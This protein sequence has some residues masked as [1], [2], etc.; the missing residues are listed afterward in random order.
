MVVLRPSK[1]ARTAAAMV[2]VAAC[3]P[4]AGIEEK[5]CVPACVDEKT[6]LV[7]D[8]KGQPHEESCVTSDETCADYYCE[9]GACAARP[10]VGRACG[11]SGTAK[12][13]EGYACLGPE[14]K[15]SAI[16][17]H[18]C[19]LADDG[20]IWCWGN[21][22]YGRLG[23]GTE[24]WG[25]NP[26]P[27]L[28][29]P[30]RA[31]AVGVGYAHTC[32]VLETGDIYC[33]GVNIAGQIGTGTASEKILEP[34]KVEVDPPGTRF[35]T[36]A[37]GLGHTC[38]LTE[39]HTVYCWGNTIEG[40]CGADAAVVGTTV[41]ARLVEGLDRVVSIETVKHH[42]CVVRDA[43]PTMMCWGSNRYLDNGHEVIVDHKLGPG[44]HGADNSAK[45][46][47]VDLGSDVLDIGMGF[48]ST[49]AVTVDGRLLAW[50]FY[51]D[52]A[53]G[54]E[55]PADDIVRDPLPVLAQS[56]R[57]VAPIR[58]VLNVIRSNG[59]D[60]CAEVS[61]AAPYGARYLCW[62]YNDNG[63]LGYADPSADGKR[64]PYGNP[65]KALPASGKQLVRGHDFA[66]AAT[67]EA[68][69]DEI[70]CYG[71]AGNLGNGDLQVANGVIPDQLVAAPVQWVPE[72][73]APFLK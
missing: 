48:E 19:V 70:W 22:K 47:P 53:T 64:F 28:H 1:L 56:T 29:L 32:A 35:T 25:T 73:F 3:A 27:V 62:G 45:P 43:A 58:F 2:V 38:A 36:V 50:G 21:N 49:F 14:L 23:D 72:H 17:E 10:A 65:V 60:Q 20:K 7:C 71:R 39:Q 6:R 52:G 67:H 34:T 30:A 40:Q 18:A 51:S 57:T 15:L 4:I 63:E 9:Q 33:W 46:V 55:R 69:A 31:T 16:E 12:C 8:A 13:N 37:A 59:S 11:P 61:D 41:R 24:Q 68:D 26:V 5:P 44:A 66:C 42:T 54:T